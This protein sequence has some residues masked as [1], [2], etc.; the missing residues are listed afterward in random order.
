MSRKTSPCTVSAEAA[1]ELLG[2]DV[3][4]LYGN[5]RAGFYEDIEQC[6]KNQQ[7]Q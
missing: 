7:E 3:R 6:E 4:T 1:A 2:V 5:M